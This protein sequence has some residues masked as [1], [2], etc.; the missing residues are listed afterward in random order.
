VTIGLSLI[1]SGLWMLERR[2][3]RLGCA[4]SERRCKALA[5]ALAALSFLAYFDFFNPNTRYPDYYHRHELYHYYLGSKYSRELGYK[6][7]YA[8]TAIAEVELGFGE[9]IRQ[10]RMTDLSAHNTIVPMTSSIVFT[11]PDQCKGRFSTERWQAFKSDVS[12]FERSSRGDYWEHMRIDHGYNP[13]PVWTLTGKLLAELAPAGDHFFKLLAALDVVLQLAALLLM[14]W[15]FGWRIMAAATVFWGCSGAA[16]CLWTG[17][18]FL[19]Q[20][21]Y[22]DLVAALCLARKR[23]S[24]LSGAALTWSTLLRVFP[25]VMFAGVGVILIGDVF[26]KR[27]LVREYWHFL[28][29]ATLAGVVLVGASAAVCGVDAYPAFVDHIRSHH[30][31]QLTNNMGL[32]TILAHGW[33][34]RMRFTTDERLDDPMQI[35]KDAHSA[36]LERLRPLWFAICLAVAAWQVWAL[37][38]TRL[39]WIGMALSVPLLICALDLTCYYYV[40]CVALAPL[41]RVRQELGP[42]YLALAGSS[43]VLLGRF[44]FIDD[45][46]VAQSWLYCAFAACVLYALSRPFSVAR[47]RAAFTV[48]RRRAAP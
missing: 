16:N 36:Q 23:K 19:R 46:Y 38:R 1:A 43:Q 9:H 32:E 3:R 6:R 2:M 13:P 26:R 10:A 44:Y 30:A 37:Q 11:D 15:A 34:N 18:A 35:W 39:L 17:G 27:R 5:L 40:F 42:A 8:C 12:W 7:L 41:L 25:I 14:G 33:D 22:F 48:P 29:G 47:L 20:D 45:R 24:A 4:P 28:L 31:T 21:W